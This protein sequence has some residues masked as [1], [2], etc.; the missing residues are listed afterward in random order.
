MKRILITMLNYYPDTPSGSVRLAFDQA[1][2]MANEGQEVWVITQDRSGNQPEYAF[3]D[4]LHVLHYQAPQVGLL[5]PRRVQGHQNAV[6][7]VLKRH[8]P[9]GVDLLHGHTLLSYDG[10]L[11]VYQNR[12]RTCYSVHS[13]VKLE[14]FATSRSTKFPQ[15]LKHHIAAHLLHRIERRCLEAS[16]VI[17]SDSAYTKEV[18]ADLHT[19]ALSQQVEVIPG[20]VDLDRFHIAENRTALK[21]QFG[22][23]EDVPVLFTLRRLVPRNGVDRLIHALRIVRNSGKTF[24]MIIGSTGPLR[25]QLE[26][27]TQELG[28]GDA[29]KFIGRV[30]D[31]DLPLMY[32]AGDV[33][34][35]PTTELECFGLITLESFAAGR[36]VIATPVGAIPEIMRRIEP[37]WLTQDASTEAIAE[38]IIAY[39]NDDTPSHSPETLRNFAQSHYNAQKIIPRLIQT[40]WGS[41]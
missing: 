18:L 33:F 6:A 41:S 32:A 1:V 23:S 10:A 40:A 35:L 30:S 8:L 19:P 5:D 22:W 7:T 24:Q 14:T 34:I 17:T 15:R 25:E 38:R 31:E 11:N 37:Q 12:V 39:L 28:L 2:H 9:D 3:R 4:G 27:L 29:V 13:P 21:R 36:P 16:D 26:A 20:W